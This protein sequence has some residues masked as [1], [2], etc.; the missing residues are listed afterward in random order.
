[1]SPTI[2]TVVEKRIQLRDKRSELKRV[3][4]EE[5]EVYKVA[6]DKLDGWLLKRLQEQGVDSV[7]TEAGTAYTTINTRASCNDWQALWQWISEQNRLD[8]LEKRVA[9]K[10]VTEYI[11][12][13]GNLPPGV[14]VNREHV[15]RVRRS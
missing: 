12:E 8:F 5:D 11:E 1:M 7:R 15:I 9:T 3:W 10:T 6:E 2:E 4:E 13:T 14:N